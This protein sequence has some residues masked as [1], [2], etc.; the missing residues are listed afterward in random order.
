MIT[1]LR[2]RLGIGQKVISTLQLSR[3]LGLS[4]RTLEGWRL[5]GDGPKWIKV[6]RT[7]RYRIAD[8]EEFE[9]GST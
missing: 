6:G 8:V 9:R 5:R 2:L 1:P 3:R 7:V 4:I